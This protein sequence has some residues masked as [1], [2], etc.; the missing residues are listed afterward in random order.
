MLA[1]GMH[2]GNCFVWDNILDIEKLVL[3]K[4]VEAVTSVGFYRHDLVV[5]SGAEGAIHAHELP[6]GGLLYVEKKE[7]LHKAFV[8]KDAPAI[9]AL[10]TL[11]PE[12]PKPAAAGGGPRGNAL[13]SLSITASALSLTGRSTLSTADDSLQRRT[14]RI[15]D[16]FTGKDAGGLDL[17]MAPEDRQAVFGGYTGLGQT[18]RS[19]TPVVPSGPVDISYDGVAM[20][21]RCEMLI[22]PL[23]FDQHAAC[24]DPVRASPSRISQVGSQ[25][26][27]AEATPVQ[28]SRAPSRVSR[29]TSPNAGK[30]QPRS[31]SD[32][33]D[34][35]D[36]VTMLPPTE[37]RWFVGYSG[38]DVFRTLFETKENRYSM[39]AGARM[40]PYSPLLQMPPP[41]ATFIGSVN[42]HTGCGSPAL[43]PPPSSHSQVMPQPSG[44]S[45]SMG[46][47]GG[48]NASL[49]GRSG[50]GARVQH[51]M[52]GQ[53]AFDQSQQT[54][55]PVK[56]KGAKPVQG[57]IGM[58]RRSVSKKDPS[59]TDATKQASL[60]S[61]LDS[62]ADAA[63]AIAAG[64]AGMPPGAQFFNDPSSQIKQQLKMRTLYRQ[65]RDLRIKQR[66]TELIAEVQNRCHA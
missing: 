29:P 32:T 17:L 46:G 48:G 57:G 45:M 54:V 28:R 61:I 63:G 52:T 8:F 39:H 26:N 56:P 59:G 10:Q 44:G 20:D 34:Q 37:Q 1:I 55:S 25:A 49:G 40:S 4:H 43:L 5:S 36:S 30:K 15:L 60:R 65:A 24:F 51:G 22:L 14:V 33:P 11:P 6:G 23:R 38:G 64:R 50:A 58:R 41:D 18:G 9:C 66:K 35:T 12:L 2:D 31:R 13:R 7:M 47:S 3:N 16:A 21:R 42:A 53:S 27:A 62:S 19:H